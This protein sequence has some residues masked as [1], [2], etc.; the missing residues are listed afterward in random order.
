MED[1]L[2]EVSDGVAP[3]LL[4]RG[5]HAREARDQALTGNRAG[6]RANAA[7]DRQRAQ[8]AL[9]GVVRGLDALDVAG[10]RQLIERAYKLKPNEY[11]LPRLLPH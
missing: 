6:P 4:A 3:L 7:Q 8:D 1:D 11:Y 5:D 9:G 2:G 10:L